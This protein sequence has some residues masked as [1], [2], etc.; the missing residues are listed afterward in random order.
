MAAV[1][2]APPLKVMV[3]VVVLTL[4]FRAVKVDELMT[5]S[6]KVKLEAVVSVAGRVMIQIVQHRLISGDR[7]V[8][9]VPVRIEVECRTGTPEPH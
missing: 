2:P 4:F 9:G 7:D 1:L 3:F 6:P 8:A 5:K